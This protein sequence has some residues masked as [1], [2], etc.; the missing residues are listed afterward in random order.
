MARATR[1]RRL[2][3]PFA[4]RVLARPHEE[5]R[6]EILHRRILYLA[7]IVALGAPLARSDARRRR[8]TPTRSIA[9]ANSAPA[10][11][12]A[13]RIWSERLAADA[14]DFES[15]WKLARA[16]LLARRPTVRPRPT[17]RSAM[18]ERGIEAGRAASSCEP[19]APDGLLLD[20]GQ[21]GRAGRVARPASGH[22]VPRRRSTRRSRR[23]CSS[24]RRSSTA[25]PTAR[26]A[27][28]TT[29]CRGSS[30]ATCGSRSSTCARRSPT[31][32]T[33]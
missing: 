23:R 11:V 17:R 16:R 21:H 30:A 10:R 5:P 1:R 14:T 19:G 8:A 27:A 32:P 12:A 24:I 20:G 18:L 22:E 29:R 6:D 25:R 7:L 3:Q 26:W 2:H 33:A 31:S 4:G 9:I 15:A 13:E 28:G